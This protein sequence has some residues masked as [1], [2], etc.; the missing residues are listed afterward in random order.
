M[1]F[2]KLSAFYYFYF[3]A[4]GIYVIFIPKV[5]HDIGYS[6]FEIGVVL[7]LAP[8]MRFLTPFLFLK[9]VKLNA[10]VFKIFLLLSLISSSLFY[11]TIEDFYLFMFNNALLGMCLSVILPYM[12]IISL[13]ELGKEKYG[14]SRLFGS[15]GFIVIALV[16][17][18]ILTNPYIAIHFY[19]CMNILIVVFAFMVLQYDKE[20]KPDENQDIEK[21]SLRKHWPFWATLFL[22]QFSFASFYNFFTIYEISHGISLETISYLWGFGVICEIIMLYFQAPVLKN[23]LFLIMKFCLLATITRWL[24]L[25]FFPDSIAMTLVSQSMHAFSFGLFHSAVIV[26]LYSLY[27][28]KKLAQQFLYAIAYGLGG[29]LGSIIAGFFYGEYLFLYAS[30]IIVLAFITLSI[31]EKRAKSLTYQSHL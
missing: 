24:L 3:S 8:L 22:M 15:I 1:L 2:S 7:A 31:Q 10:S 13:N 9:Y 17:A 16:L 29:F 6:A 27:H 12:E 28:Q 18:K 26:Y 23:N 30:F 21:F 25:F 20:I 19:L 4:V 5:L 11:L 14:K